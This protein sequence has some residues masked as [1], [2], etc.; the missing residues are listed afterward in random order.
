[1]Y[2]MNGDD[3]DT[4]FEYFDKV[5]KDYHKIN[6]K[7]NHITNWDLTT[8]Q[9][10][11]NEM[12]CEN[13]ILDLTKLGLGETSMRVRVGR[14]LASFPLPGAMTRDD[15]VRMENTMITAFKK[16]M[17]DKAFGGTYYSLTPGSPFQLSDNVTSKAYRRNIP[18]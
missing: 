15:R 7:I 14:N 12:G 11:L 17:T 8:Q 13:G 2:A 9:V 16:L 6:T 1:M 5:I 18:S 10:R 3:Y 4:F